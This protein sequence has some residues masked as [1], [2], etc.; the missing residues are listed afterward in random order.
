[1]NRKKLQAHCHR[2]EEW[3]TP[4]GEKRFAMINAN[5]HPETGEISWDASANGGRIEKFWHEE[6]TTDGRNSTDL[7]HDA[8][9]RRTNRMAHNHPEA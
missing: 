9:T 2:Q 4:N 3:T 7:V 6:R 1:M 5:Q 8:R